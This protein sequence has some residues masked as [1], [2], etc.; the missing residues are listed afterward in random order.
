MREKADALC[1]Q[2]LAEKGKAFPH[3]SRRVAPRQLPPGEAFFAVKAEKSSNFASFCNP[4]VCARAMQA[5]SLREMAFRFYGGKHV[6][7]PYETVH[8]AGQTVGHSY[9][10]AV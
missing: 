9:M 10:R 8:V 6:C 5:F 7:L 1:H 2:R 4:S 3:Q